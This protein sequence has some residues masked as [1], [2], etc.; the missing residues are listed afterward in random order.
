MFAEMERRKVAMEISSPATPTIQEV[1]E[2]V[3]GAEKKV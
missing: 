1:Q 2:P 3:D